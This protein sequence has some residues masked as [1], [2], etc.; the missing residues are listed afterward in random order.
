MDCFEDI[1]E[2][3]YYEADVEKRLHWSELHHI[4]T[5]RGITIAHMNSS[6]IM[7]YEIIKEHNNVIVWR[8]TRDPM[9]RHCINYRII[10]DSDEARIREYIDL[11]HKI[12]MFY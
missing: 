11:Y 8:N 3:A 6:L 9:K 12:V 5:D 10:E 7:V 4:L 2:K 1:C